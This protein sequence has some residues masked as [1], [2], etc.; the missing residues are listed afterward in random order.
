MVVVA[1]GKIA[2]DS[3]R[4]LICQ[5]FVRAS[6]FAAEVGPSRERP[7][8]LVVVADNSCD[9]VAPVVAKEHRRSRGF[10]AVLW[11]LREHWICM[12]MGRMLVV[13][14]EHS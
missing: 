4:P 8:L 14:V 1:V 7:S 9:E 11:L 12:Q 3:V 5:N 13:R 6:R 10:L 2:V